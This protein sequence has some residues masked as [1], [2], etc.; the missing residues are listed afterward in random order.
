MWMDRRQRAPLARHRHARRDV[1]SRLLGARVS[2][3][4]GF[5]AV[6]VAGVVG[7][8]LGLVAGF[9]GGR[10]DDLLMRLGDMQLAFPVL[11]LAIAV[12][13]GA[14]REPRQRDR[15][16]RP[17]GVGHLR[18]DRARRDAVAAAPRVRGGRPALGARRRGSCGG[19]SCRT[20]CR[21]SRWWPPS[22]SHG[23]SSPRRRCRSW[24]S[25]SRRPRRA[26][27]PCS[28]RG[29]TT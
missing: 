2:L 25:A 28:T 10:L 26:G 13:Y 1:V 27:A 7:V 9:Y 5:A 12:L 24:G 15:R 29:G 19:T 4:V 20:S 18:A 14:R 22:P 11:V 8:A 3:L 6:L 21:R 23:R 17:D 16:A